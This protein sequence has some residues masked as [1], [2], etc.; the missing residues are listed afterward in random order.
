MFEPLAENDLHA[1]RDLKI[2]RLH[3]DRSFPSMQDEPVAERGEVRN[4]L[5]CR[6]CDILTLKVPRLIV[7]RKF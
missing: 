1:V 6:I 5:R 4:T 2:T 7:T 3:R